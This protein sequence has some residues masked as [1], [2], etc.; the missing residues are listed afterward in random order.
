VRRPRFNRW[1][2]A[3]LHFGTFARIFGPK[4]P[5]ALVFASHQESSNLAQQFFLCYQPPQSTL[6]FSQNA[7]N[8]DL[9]DCVIFVT[10]WLG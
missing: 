4:L 7:D 8:P 3:P 2:Q 9:L 1:G 5:R 6:E 10:N